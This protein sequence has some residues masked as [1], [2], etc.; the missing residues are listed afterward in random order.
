MGLGL[1]RLVIK[2]NVMKEIQEFVEAMDL[3]FIELNKMANN[4]DNNLPERLACQ[5]S[6]DEI[7][8]VRL[9]DKYKALKAKMAHT[10]AT[11]PSNG[12]PV[13]QNV[14]M[15]HTGVKSTTNDSPVIQNP[16]KKKLKTLMGVANSDKN[17]K[18]FLRIH[19]DMKFLMRNLSEYLEGEE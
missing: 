10:R 3:R 2:G 6:A 18:D 5:N 8:T 17:Y 14:E 19:D 9:S 1:C 13:T 4:E 11:D 7:D 15:T 12:S 16:E